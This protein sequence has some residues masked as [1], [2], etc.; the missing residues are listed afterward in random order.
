MSNN[1]INTNDDDIEALWV[2][3]G[4]KALKDNENNVSAYLCY[5]DK[6]KKQSV[7]GEGG[8]AFQTAKELLDHRKM[9]AF[10]CPCG[11]GFH[12]CEERGSI[13]RHLKTF[14]KEILAKL[15]SDGLDMK[16]SWIYPD[17]DNNSYTLTK[18]MPTFDE[19]SPIEAAGH[20]LSITPPKRVDASFADKKIKSATNK[21]KYVPF[22]MEHKEKI[23]HD[24][25]KAPWAGKK[26][27]NSNVSFSDVI[28][29]QASQKTDTMKTTTER[30]QHYAQ[31][32]MRK[33]KQCVNGK[34]CEKKDR[35]FACAFNHDENGDIIKYGTLLT[36][37]ILCP[38][39]RPPFM[40]CGDGNCTHI[41]LEGRNKFIQEK[42]QSFYNKTAASDTT[43]STNLDKG[44]YIPTSKKTMQ[45]IAEIVKTLVSQQSDDEWEGEHTPFGEDTPNDTTNDENDE[46]EDED[47]AGGISD[48]V[49]AARL[50]AR[51]VNA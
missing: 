16:K 39:E 1:N 51:V 50:S 48:E 49:F 41:H 32:D 36:N 43:C 44:I 5:C 25:P 7:S 3:G 28:K 9:K 30:P 29:E 31:E 35:P 17:N 33:E 10:I 15:E 27:S 11:C 6:C 12:I 38:F 20:I 18:P 42:K 2:M 4:A 13:I 34:K 19:S 23:Y 8:I 40:R 22:N 45:D 47:D 46:D 26:L 21:Q 37:D 24:A 14:H